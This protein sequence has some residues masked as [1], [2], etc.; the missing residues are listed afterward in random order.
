MPGEREPKI[1]PEGLLGEAEPLGG[2]PARATLGQL[3][4]SHDLEGGCDRPWLAARSRRHEAEF[5]GRP[6]LFHSDE[7]R[8]DADFI[9][10]T[11]GRAV[12][13]LGADHGG[14]KTGRHH[15]G[16]RHPQGREECGAGFFHTTEV[17]DVRDDP[18]TIGVVKL[19]RFRDFG[20]DHGW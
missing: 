16:G 1:F 12:I 7:P 13:D 3:D 9:A 6:H 14:E 5:A 11:G 2:H 10:E 15:L 18:A 4:E 19:D 17:G 20:F 8:H